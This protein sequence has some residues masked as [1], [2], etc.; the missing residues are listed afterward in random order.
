[1]KEKFLIVQIVRIFT[2]RNYRVSD[3]VWAITSKFPINITKLLDFFVLDI[4]SFTSY[5]R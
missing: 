1:M 3:E 5:S 2:V 4:Q